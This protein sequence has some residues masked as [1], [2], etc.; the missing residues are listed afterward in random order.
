MHPRAVAPLTEKASSSPRSR[1]QAPISALAE[2]LLC[3]V[4]VSSSFSCCRS[5]TSEPRNEPHRNSM[6]IASHAR[7]GIQ[8]TTEPCRPGG[9]GGRVEPDAVAIAAS[10]SA[11][12]A[13]A[14]GHN[15]D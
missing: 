5:L 10:S 6:E 1:N 12:V 4:M 9:D 13:G 8:G 7:P 15:P 2:G 11:A 3:V 14:D